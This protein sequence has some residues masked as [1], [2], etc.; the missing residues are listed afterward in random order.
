MSEDF[1]TN[2]IISLCTMSNSNLPDSILEKSRISFITPIKVLADI[3]AFST[4]SNCIL[5]SLVLRNNSVKPIMPFRG[6]RISWLVLERNSDFALLAASAR[7]LACI[8]SF[9][10]STLKRTSPMKSQKLTSI[11]V[12]MSVHRR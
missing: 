8:S 1:S 5:F 9:S 12:S 3:M 6:V 7:F 2:C 11:P 10:R 4:Y